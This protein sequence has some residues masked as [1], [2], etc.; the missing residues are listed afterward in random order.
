MRHRIALGLVTFLTFSTSGVAQESEA[1]EPDRS[2]AFVAATRQ[3]SFYSDLRVNAHDFLLSRVASEEPVEPAPECVAG[4]PDA[5]REAFD[6][7]LSHYGETLTGR[8]PGHDRLMLALRYELVGYPDVDVLPDSAT[9]PTLARLEAALPAYRACWWG[10]HDKRN[11]AWIADAVPL[12]IAH[13]DTLRARLA[14]AYR[15]EWGGPVP[16]D[17]AGSVNFGGANTV[18]NPDNVMITAADPAYGNHGAL[19]MLFHE[20]SHTLSG[21]RAGGAIPEALEAASREVSGEP[22]PR[23]LWHVVL[24]YTA[25]R[26]VQDLLEERGASGYEPY[27]YREGL[28]ARAWPEYQEPLEHHWEAYLEGRIGMEEAARRLLGA[29]VNTTDP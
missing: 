25:G 27:V 15:A 16:V 2:N 11:R 24:F 23:N 7:A 5:E 6:R 17:V 22:P 20:A 10:H 12:L 26:V 3:F 21:P 19:E 18:V 28:F 29:I 1:V 4:L 13:E 9:A 8:N 14:R